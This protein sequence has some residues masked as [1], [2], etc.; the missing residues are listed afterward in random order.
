MPVVAPAVGDPVYAKFGVDTGN[1]VNIFGAY[2]MAAYQTAAQ[3]LGAAGSFTA[4]TGYTKIM[5]TAS[6]FVAATGVF[7]AP[8]TG[9]YEVSA[10]ILFNSGGTRNIVSIYRNGSAYFSSPSPAGA[11]T[12]CAAVLPVIPI[13]LTAS[14]TVQMYAYNGSAGVST[15]VGSTAANQSSFLYISRVS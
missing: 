14:D 2:Y 8:A 13:L 9:L 3:L 6:A 12:D 15:F 5:D 11:T 4:I 10:Q 7:T 1:A